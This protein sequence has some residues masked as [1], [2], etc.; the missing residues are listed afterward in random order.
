MKKHQ[1]HSIFTS[2]NIS[3]SHIYGRYTQMIMLWK[4]MVKKKA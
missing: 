1:R 3:W 4:L 2:V